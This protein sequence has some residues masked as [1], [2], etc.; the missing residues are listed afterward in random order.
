MSKV[1][2]QHWEAD[3]EAGL[4]RRGRASCDYEAYVPDLLTRRE[5]PLFGDVAADVVDA[6]VAISRFDAGAAALA[7]TEAL[8]RL[9]LRA[10]SVA[11]SKIEGLEVGAGRLLRAE[12]A[13]GLGEPAEDV[14]AKE[15]LGNIQAMT[16][17]LQTLQP[18]DDI[19]VPILLEAHRHLLAGTRMEEYGGRIR[20]QQNWIGGSSYN[21]CSAS[22]VPPPHEFVPDLLEDLCV[23]CNTDNLPAVAQAA[24]A[25]AQFETI[26]PFIDG[27]GRI[28]RALI[29]LV[30]RRRRLTTRVLPPI[31][32][33]L[34]T[35]ANDYVAG[36]TA[37]RYLG[38]PQDTHAVDGLN[39]WI[40]LFAAACGR[41]V[42]DAVAFEEH[43]KALQASW[44]TTLGSIRRDSAADRLLNALPGTPVVTVGSAA[45]LIGRTFQAT[46]EAI[47]RLADARIL[48]QVSVGRR[49]RA[50]EATE[51]IR[52]FTDLERQLASPGGDT[53]SSAPARAVPYRRPR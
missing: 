9:L 29:H 11:S 30:L 15:V 41:A 18:G 24:A 49:N 22:F 53:R 44:R 13:T 21:P 32:L 17:A 14:T 34:A 47:S 23:F 12:V 33:I 35:W 43:I 51:L 7:D 45:S 8:A 20:E 40:G 4:P 38:D 46:N 2:S 5:I 50:F 10:E 39:R 42:D 52:L 6:E 26:H 25:H 37:T 48:R 28:G 31:S 19:T 1:V 16:W 36:L 3:I 27:N